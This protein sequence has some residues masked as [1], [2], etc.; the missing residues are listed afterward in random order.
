METW[1]RWWNCHR[2]WLVICICTS[3]SHVSIISA[4]PRL[5]VFMC[6]FLR[7]I[8][9]LKASGSARMP[10]QNPFS[11]LS[12][13]LWWAVK[14]FDVCGFSLVSAWACF[15]NER[16]EWCVCVCV[17]MCVCMCVCARAL[18]C[19]QRGRVTGL[20]VSNK[21]GRAVCAHEFATRS[22]CWHLSIATAWSVFSLGRLAHILHGLQR[23]PH[24][25]FHSSLISVQM[26]V[27]EPR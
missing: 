17:C 23:H 3:V 14:S 21:M 1:D 12:K 20:C 10:C 11:S 19:P 18:S 6:D 4:E 7:M 2:V 5:Y 15:N 22:G 13:S 24:S 26:R 25:H 27:R 8:S 16:A 9:E